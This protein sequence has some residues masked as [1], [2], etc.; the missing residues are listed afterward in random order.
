MLILSDNP[1]VCFLAFL[2]LHLPFF[3][4]EISLRMV[5]MKRLW[6]SLF[7]P[8]YIFSE[9]LKLLLLIVERLVAKLVARLSGFKSNPDISQKY[10]MGDISKGVANAF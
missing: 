9:L 5:L 8:L 6:F 4:T 7:Q 10:K 3:S 1:S 2:P